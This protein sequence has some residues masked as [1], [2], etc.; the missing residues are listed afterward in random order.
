MSETGFMREVAYLGVK[1]SVAA[2]GPTGF[3]VEG[4][5]ATVVT[6]DRYRVSPTWSLNYQF[7]SSELP[8]GTRCLLVAST[9]DSDFGQ[10]G[11]LAGVQLTQGAVFGQDNVIP[12]GAHRGESSGLDHWSFRQAHP[13][14]HRS[15]QCR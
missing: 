3:E 1:G 13:G 15:A 8:V 2:V 5:L 12:R 9:Q 10:S 14:L 4:D 6:G 7:I 11:D